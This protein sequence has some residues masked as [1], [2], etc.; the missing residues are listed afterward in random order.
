VNYERK[1]TQ[2]G[3]GELDIAR[4]GP[5]GGADCQ[6]NKAVADSLSRQYTRDEERYRARIRA[7][8]EL[9]GE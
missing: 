3:S 6:R 8:K 1:L 2:G 9:L 7:I 4:L 5:D